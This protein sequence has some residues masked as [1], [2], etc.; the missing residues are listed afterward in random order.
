MNHHP[1]TLRMFLTRVWGVATVEWVRFLFAAGVA[2]I[3]FYVLRRER[4]LSRKIIH[5]FPPLKDLGREAALS[6]L[7]CGIY[8]IVGVCSWMAVRGHWI[9]PFFRA[10]LP[11]RVWFWASIILTIF[12]HDTYFYWTHRL[13]HLPR[14][15][16]WM[17]RSHHRSTNPTPWAA[18][19]FDPLEA[20]VQAGIF[21]L[22]LIL[23]PIH[24]VAF[25]LFMAWQITFNVLGHSGF[26]IYPSWFMDSWLG[27][28]LNTPTNH[29]MHH[30]YFR[31][32]YGLYFNV[33]D[34]L[35]GTNHSQYEERFRDVTSG[36]V[37]TS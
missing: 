36:K 26:E 35:M 33:W 2:W 23:Y 16:P 24:P 8:G 15:F 12:L 21:P 3:F 11:G 31:G 5:G 22:V 19:A 1:E 20:V 34:R 32:N 7:T 13:M 6:A 30:Q 28:F 17:H 18:Y 27:K 25:L 10:G 37:S 9:H 29:A 14:L 4:W